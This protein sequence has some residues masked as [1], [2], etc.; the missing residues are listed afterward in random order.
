[1]TY[2][3][4]PAFAAELAAIIETEIQ[5]RLDRAAFGR[6]EPHE[7]RDLVRWLEGAR[8]GIDI[9]FRSDGR[10]HFTQ[11]ASST[12]ILVG[13]KQVMPGTSPG[14]SASETNPEAP[15]TTTTTTTETTTP[16]QEPTPG[17]DP[18]PGGDPAP[19]ADDPALSS[20]E[21]RFLP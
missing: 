10:V 3:D 19:P 15:A 13:V 12:G 17:A 11:Q 7:V 20:W 14:M 18:D 4:R 1:M 16:P 8:D 21:S 2:I 9:E 6:I 5:D